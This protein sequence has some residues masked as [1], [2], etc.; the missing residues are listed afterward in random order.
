MAKVQENAPRS[1]VQQAFN[2]GLRQAIT[3]LGGMGGA[4][5]V[6]ILADKGSN[7][8]EFHEAVEF[9]GPHMKGLLQLVRTSA[10]DLEQKLRGSP[11]LSGSTI[12]EERLLPTAQ[13]AKE[14]DV[15]PTSSNTEYMPISVLV[16]NQGVKTKK[17][18]DCVKH[19][20]AQIR[21]STALQKYARPQTGS[22]QISSD[23]AS[24]TKF[25]RLIKEYVASQP[26]SESKR[27]R[28][29]KA[30]AP[31]VS[32]PNSPSDNGAEYISLSN[33]LKSLGVLQRNVANAL[34]HFREQIEAS[35]TPLAK[36]SRKR[37]GGYQVQDT[38]DARR[39]GL[40]L[41]TAYDPK[42]LETKRARTPK[43]TA[44]LSNTA[45]VRGLPRQEVLS[46]QAILRGSAE[47]SL[48]AS[49]ILN[50]YE[51]PTAFTDHVTGKLG[52]MLG[53]PLVD[54]E[55]HKLYTSEQAERI[56]NLWFSEEG[57]AFRKK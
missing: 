22:F 25:E 40:E 10:P 53:K 35:A 17:R 39:Y 29:S 16:R 23:P 37:T 13:D 7:S 49:E 33:F 24:L 14:S 54:G 50:R 44:G 12:N 2:S 21:E 3:Q 42:L 26:E 20:V 28:K 56:R 9:Y 27:G 32:E 41:I 18:G 57:V 11:S 47:R 46:A 45:S 4:E 55:G 51:V 1:N 6:Y 8:K 15:A 5:L 30:Y 19:I 52:D 34:P 38:E 36:L 48:D 43:T 31:R